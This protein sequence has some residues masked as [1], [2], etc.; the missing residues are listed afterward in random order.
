MSKRVVFGLIILAFASSGCG[1]Y[2]SQQGT[3]RA[4]A[5]KGAT[6]TVDGSGNEMDTHSGSSTPQSHGASA[7]GAQTFKVSGVGYNS[8][9]VSVIAG[10]VLKIKFSP[11]M[12]ELS[13]TTS[14]GTEPLPYSILGVYIKV[15]NAAARPTPPL[16]NGY[17]GGT[18]E[19]SPEMDFSSAISGDPKQVTITI[20]QPNNN[21][22]CLQRYTGCP[23]SHVQTGEPWNG[24]LTVE[25][26]AN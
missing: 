12:Q 25:T 20:Q 3:G 10:R 2:P 6:D 7:S 11:G 13:G 21:A 18:T 8:T 9:T 17:Y 5:K 23:Y 22:I 14:S 1:I 16:Y 19:T 4:F 24:T 15:G 26:D